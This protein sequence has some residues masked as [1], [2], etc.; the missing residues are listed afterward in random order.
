[1]HISSLGQCVCGHTDKH[2]I[3]I[4]TI[5]KYG[6]YVV[7]HPAFCNGMHVLTVHVLA[8]TWLGFTVA[9]KASLVC[10]SMLRSSVYGR[11]HALKVSST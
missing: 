9:T 2:S 4:L 6:C 11:S 10:C 5:Y 7:L 1:M 3:F 8:V